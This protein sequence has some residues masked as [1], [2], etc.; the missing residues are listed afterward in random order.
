M[1][2]ILS[3]NFRNKIFKL[4]A[5]C[6]QFNEHI[7]VIGKKG[8]A[9]LISEEEYEGWQATQEISKKPK[10]KAAILKRRDSKSNDFTGVK[11]CEL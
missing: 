10:L 3:T 7:K 5:N 11:V 1:T 9:V 8:N 6:V 2:T 4:L